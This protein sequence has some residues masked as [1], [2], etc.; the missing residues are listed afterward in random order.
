VAVPLSNKL[1]DGRAGRAQM[2][3]LQGDDAINFFTNGQP[4]LPIS[5]IALL[6]LQ[7]LPMGCAKV[8]K[9]LLAVH[10]DD[11]QITA[12][13][14]WN[15]LKENQHAVIQAQIVGEDKLPNTTRS[16]K[17]LLVEALIAADHHRAGIERRRKRGVSLTA[18]HFSNGKSSHLAIYHLPLEITD[19]LLTA[20]SLHPDVWQQLVQRA[21][22]LPGSKQQAPEERESRKNYLYE[23]LLEVLHDPK[24]LKQFIRTYFLRIPQHTPFADDPRRGYTL[25]NETSLISWPLFELFLVKVVHMD[26][27]R[28]ARICA[29]GDGLAIYVQQTGG[30]KFFHNF[31]TERYPASFRALLI[32]ANMAHIKAGNAPLFDMLTYNTIFEDGD[33]IMRPDW[34]LARD[35]V[36]MRII[37]Q[38]HTHPDVIPEDE[39]A[40]R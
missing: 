14:A 1:P 4:G 10:A 35:L 3:L 19:F 36:L 27:E 20:Q 7:F 13:F 32:K 21:W 23:D 38:L 6:A 5:G 18:Y 8:G 30:K 33:E 28:L 2:P 15:F 34:Q 29:L 31:F 40:E 22:Q 39:A 26:A 25:R 17:T 9:G 16:L 11:D 37:D 24:L 12:A